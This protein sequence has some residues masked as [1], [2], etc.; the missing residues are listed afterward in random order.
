MVER[1]RPKVRWP[2]LSMESDQ[3][4]RCAASPEPH[5]GHYEPIGGL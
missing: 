4:N 3:V 2:N 5:R 1:G